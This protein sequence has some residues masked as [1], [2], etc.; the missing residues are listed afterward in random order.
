MD[1]RWYCPEA[2]FGGPACA[3]RKRVCGTQEGGSIGVWR[4]ELLAAP[5]IGARLL[6]DSYRSP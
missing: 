6:C 1:L 4:M 3:S 2:Y 5:E